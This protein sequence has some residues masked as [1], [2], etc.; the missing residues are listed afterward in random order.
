MSNT[1]QKL[2]RLKGITASGEE[3]ELPELAELQLEWDTGLPASILLSPEHLEGPS[4]SL[5]V[6]SGEDDEDAL[7]EYG[8]IVLRPGASNIVDISIETESVEAE[9]G[10]GNDCDCG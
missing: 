7:T 4:M 10:C 5:E 3:I 6:G 9:E 8:V 2:P 1:P